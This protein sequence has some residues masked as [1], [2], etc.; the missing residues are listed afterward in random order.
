MVLF[1]FIFQMGYFKLFNNNNNNE[2]VVVYVL[3]CFLKDFEDIFK[4]C[5]CVINYFVLFLIFVIVIYY[6][7]INIY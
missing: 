2:L 3:N 7:V 1:D 6:F 4:Y 5:D